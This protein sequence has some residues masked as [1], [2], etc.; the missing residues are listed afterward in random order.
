MRWHL[1]LDLKG[2]EPEVQILW[3]E[4]TAEVKAMW[5]E[6]MCM[7]KSHRAAHCVSTPQEGEAQRDV[8]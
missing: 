1:N 8:S 5:W 3:K 4:L 6:Y 7:C 2:K